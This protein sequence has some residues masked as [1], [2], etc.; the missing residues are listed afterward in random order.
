MDAVALRRIA[1]VDLCYGI[2]AAVILAFGF[3]RAVF[4]AK[5][6]AFYQ[7]NALFWAKIGLFFLVGLISVPPT[8][9]YLRWNREGAE[10]PTDRE[11]TVIRRLI[12][13]EVGLFAALPV[14]AAAMA[15]GYG[16]NS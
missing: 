14:L 15:R 10:A 1:S 5:G 2:L 6:W 11:I 12:W 3:A 8:M 9:T 13:L 7:H 16:E 4:A